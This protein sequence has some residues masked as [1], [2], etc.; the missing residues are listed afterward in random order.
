MPPGQTVLRRGRQF[1]HHLH[2]RLQVGGNIFATPGGDQFERW[3][4]VPEGL[5]D[6]IVVP[7]AGDHGPCDD[8]DLDAGIHHPVGRGSRVRLGLLSLHDLG[9]EARFPATPDHV[10][11]AAGVEAAGE[12][13]EPIVRE[14]THGDRIPPCEGVAPGESGNELDVQD[15]L[16]LYR[17]V[18][19]HSEHEADV[20]RTL[21]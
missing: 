13:Y 20:E 10:V 6:H 15:V 8:A 3:R 16:E 14:L 17:L 12:Q 5:E 19:F 1:P 9:L 21:A 4:G 18:L 7:V 11:V 2:K